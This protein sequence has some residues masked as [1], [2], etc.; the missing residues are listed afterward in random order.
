M[1]IRPVTQQDMESLVIASE[2]W[3]MSRKE[4]VMSNIT[5][6]Y[7]FAGFDDGTLLGVAGIY[8]LWD[9]VG[10]GWLLFSPSFYVGNRR[11]SVVRRVR[12]EFDLLGI[13]FDRVQIHVDSTV[14]NGLEFARFL[15]FNVE[16]LMEKYCRGRDYWLL[17]RV[18]R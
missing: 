9:G 1:V 12:R 11:I 18:R 4:E 13:L 3:I 6:G 8:E 15:G 5:R 2:P 7:S 16:G 17:S 10:E 14:E